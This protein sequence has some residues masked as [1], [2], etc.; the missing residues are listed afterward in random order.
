MATEIEKLIVEMD[1]KVDEYMADMRKSAKVT[2][3]AVDDITK[4]LKRM[5]K[6]QN[7][8]AKSSSN[9]KFHVLAAATAVAAVGVG[10]INV[11]K[12]FQTY[13]ASLKTATGSTENAAMA[14]EA[15]QDFAATTPFSI[16]KSIEAFVKLRNMGLDPGEAALQSYGNT[17]VALGKDLS[18]MIEAVADAATGEFERLK[19]FGIKSKSIGDEVAF[20]FQGQTTRVGKNAEEITAFLQSI[21]NENFAGAMEEQFNTLNGLMSNFGD[22][23]DR[24]AKGIGDAGFT[25]LISEMFSFANAELEEFANMINSGEVEARLDAVF[26]QFAGFGKDLDGLFS[27]IGDMWNSLMNEIPD[28]SEES[29]D[30]AGKIFSNFPE[31]FRAF[32]KVATVEFLDFVNNLIDRSE[33]LVDAVAAI[34]TDDTIEAAGKRLDTALARNASIRQ[35]TIDGIF[36]EMEADIAATEVKRKNA[37]GLTEKFLQEREK[38]RKANEDENGDVLS[39]FK[40]EGEDGG[41]GAKVSA[42]EKKELEALQ[43]SRQRRLDDIQKRQEDQA[44]ADQTA[45]EALAARLESEQELI[46]QAEESKLLTEIEA[47]EKRKELDDEYRAGLEELAE[48]DLERLYERLELDLE[49]QEQLL[50]KKLIN[51]EQYAL[52]VDK[53]N[54][55]G[56]EERIKLAQKEA[57]AKAGLENLTL[58][59]AIGAIETLGKKSEKAAKAAFYIKKIQKGSE[60]FVN[61]AAA[62]TE[63]LPNYPLAAATGIAG[64]LEIAAIASQEFEGGSNAPTPVAAPDLSDDSSSSSSEEFQDVKVDDTVAGADGSFNSNAQVIRFEA[65]AGDTVAEALAD[66]LN[67]SQKN[68]KSKGST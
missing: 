6:R 8:T 62:V 53:I 33:Y 56:M 46:D 34:F 31:H 68:G 59:T 5:S 44:A 19:E 2:D 64:A 65:E 42:K 4:D 21:G 24:I 12:K 20:T 28:A 7:S 25:E 27:T 10:I 67:N 39:Q 60:A 22:N 52:N 29:V 3:K 61:T 36:A 58:N 15:L 43:N 1:A 26:Q 55:K 23:V 51:E 30:M 13:E 49:L 32:I 54:R 50:D 47:K 9:L 40:I 45:V 18:Q 63:A 35:D 11:A 41:D 66:A 16:D 48:T 37:E 57:R 38:R 14:M 17:A